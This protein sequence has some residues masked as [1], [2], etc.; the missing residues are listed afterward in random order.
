MPRYVMASRRAGKFH[1][2]EK[3]AARD[4]IDVA[5]NEFSAGMSVVNDLNPADPQARRTVVFDADPG[6]MAQLAGEVPNDVI[7]EPEIL[8]YTDR[9]VLQTDAGVRPC[10]STNSSCCLVSQLPGVEWLQ[11]DPSRVVKKRGPQR[12]TALCRHLCTLQVNLAGIESRRFRSQLG[13]L[14]LSEG[15]TLPLV[16]VLG[17]EC[18]SKPVAS[19][20]C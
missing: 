4:A 6:E 17:R 3:E 16:S 13:P 5:V 20:D 1:E 7:L 15:S 2:H 10:K 12:A 8:H 18:A 14:P 9:I 11:H 19:Q